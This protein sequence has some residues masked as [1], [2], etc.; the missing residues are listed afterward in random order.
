MSDGAMLL[1]I[2]QAALG[3]RRKTFCLSMVGTDTEFSAWLEGFDEAAKIVA[4]Q[5]DPAPGW[6]DIATA[7]RDRTWFWAYAD[8]YGRPVLRLVH[9]DDEY[10]RLP[11]DHTGRSWPTAPTLWRVVDT[12]LPPALAAPA[13]EAC[14]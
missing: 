6:Q 8:Y 1:A 9:F 11:I 13:I 5:A 3:E 10:D 7:P 12:P 4:A 2:T 14:K